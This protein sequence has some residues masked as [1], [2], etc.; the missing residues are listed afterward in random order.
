MK[1]VSS[2]AIELRDL[3][4]TAD[5]GTYG[6]NDS[7]PDL[8]LLDL[9]LGIAVDRVVISDDGMAHVFDYDP[10]VR[11]IDR[12]AA[13]G[14]YETQ[15][16][17]ITRIASACAAYPAIQRMEICLKK[18]SVRSGRG[19]LG[20]RLTLDE[21]ATDALRPAR[22]DLQGVLNGPVGVET[23]S[24]SSDEAHACGLAGMFGT[25][26]H[27]GVAPLPDA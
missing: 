10:L 22:T 3:Q 8:H 18:S 14:H 6:P 2:A 20:V 21:L 17:L 24:T 1:E 19:T 16:R 5:I 13:D 27:R 26:S 4:L 25:V 11:E 23:G 9:T 15:E 12:L 7:R